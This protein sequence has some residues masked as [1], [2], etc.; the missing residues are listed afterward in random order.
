[1]KQEKRN[2]L[3]QKCKPLEAT[4]HTAS[5]VPKRSYQTKQTTQIK[6]LIIMYLFWDQTEKGFIKT[7]LPLWR[8]IEFSVLVATLLSKAAK[9]S[10]WL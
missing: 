3:R 10:C 5:T 8:R 9:L 6:I 2:P 1:V 4:H 7:T